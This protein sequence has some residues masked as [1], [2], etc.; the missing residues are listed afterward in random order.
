LIL[1]KNHL[2]LVFSK[3]TEQNLIKSLLGWSLCSPHNSSPVPVAQVSLSDEKSSLE[4]LAL[5]DKG[6]EVM[7]KAHLSHWHWWTKDKK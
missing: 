2:K 1:T 7:R 5:V 6:Q 3:T 4:P